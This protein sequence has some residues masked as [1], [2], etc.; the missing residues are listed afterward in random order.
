MSNSTICSLVPKDASSDAGVAG[1]GVL[2][3]FIITAA[4][5]V[6]LSATIIL[7]EL[8]RNSEAK[9][10]RKI[11]LS[12][13]D[14]Q[15]LTGIGIQT[16]GLVKMDSIVPYHFFIIWMLSMLS[17]ATHGA[18]LL[19]LVNDF[20]R[21][22]VLRWLRQF[23][24]FINLV[25]SCTYGV[26]VAM[27]VTKDLQP[28][29]PISCVWKIPAR[30]APSYLGI[31]IVGT[32]AVMAG[33]CIVFALGVWFLHSRRERWNKIIQVAGLAVLTAIGVGAA[34]RV[35]LLSQ[36]FGSPSVSLRDTN[37]KDWSFG[38]L[39]PLLLLL[40]P[41]MS[42]IELIRG[43][44]RVPAPVMEGEYIGEEKNQARLSFEP[45]PFWGSRSNLVAK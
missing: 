10:Y 42:V 24:M 11:L 3:S 28:T 6:L 44:M 27:N 26:L 12:F 8:R 40:L 20:R 43:E 13:S 34:I 21:D 35:I 22:W 1:A 39:L 17:T 37:E 18:A 41:L 19:A 4:L 14:Q 32:I 2:L 38:Q 36:A 5:S 30:K 9:I 25:L 16:V 29:L 23:L 31:S 7:S 33:S 45:N 15:I